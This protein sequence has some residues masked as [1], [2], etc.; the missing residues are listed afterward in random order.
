MPTETWADYRQSLGTKPG[1][2]GL[3]AVTNNAGGTRV[4]KYNPRRVSFLIVNNEANRAH[5]FRRSGDVATT[6]G[7][8]LDALGGFI[9]GNLKDDGR[10]V[11]DEVYVILETAAGNVYVEEVE[12]A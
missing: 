6:S 5:A 1:V 2:T 12:E 8:P 3:V 9:Q 7:V 10:S 4:L 11:E